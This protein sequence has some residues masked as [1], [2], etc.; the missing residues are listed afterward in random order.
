MNSSYTQKLYECFGAD[1]KC[2]E[3]QSEEHRLKCFESKF[4]EF[5]QDQEEQ[6]RIAIEN[7]DK[8]ISGLKSMISSLE[9]QRDGLT[10]MNEIQTKMKD[11]L[12]FNRIY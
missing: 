4:K 3:G 8:K 12:D 2:C 9:T 1:L 6:K 11:T 7:R 10:N 5:L